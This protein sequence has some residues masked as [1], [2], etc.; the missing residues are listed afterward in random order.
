MKA[1]LASAAILLAA[2]AVASAEEGKRPHGPKV[3]PQVMMMKHMDANGDAKV[4]AAEFLAF[5]TAKSK[6]HF[7]KLD[8]DGDGVVTQEEFQN[9]AAAMAM[10]AFSRMDRNSDGKISKDDQAKVRGDAARGNPDEGRP[11][12]PKMKKRDHHKH[13]DARDGGRRAEFETKRAERRAERRAQQAEREAAEAVQ[14][15]PEIVTE[16]PAAE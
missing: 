8:A 7:A 3:S 11:H 13:H 1:I 15:E 4:D 14:T 16:A 12:G 10:S 2:T 6:E 9:A 5:T